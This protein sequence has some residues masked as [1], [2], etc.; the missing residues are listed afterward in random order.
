VIERLGRAL[1]KVYAGKGTHIETQADTELTARIDEGDLTELL[2]VCM[3]NAAK[4]G[5]GHVHVA[6]ATTAEGLRIVIDDDG[7]GFPDQSRR[8]LLERGARADT[9]REGQGLGLAVAAD[10]VRSYTGRLEL[11][12]NDHGGGR[13]VIVLP[14]A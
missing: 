6:A 2:G 14:S 5:N 7:P 9:T 3:D 11:H 12:T 8:D 1:T 13:V 4:Y 10:I